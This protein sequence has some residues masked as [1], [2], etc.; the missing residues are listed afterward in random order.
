[1][2]VSEASK[3]LIWLKNFLEELG[4]EQDNCVLYFDNQ[5]VVH[6]GKNPVFHSRTKHIKLRYHFI[7][8]LVN[9]GTLL[10]SKIL[11]SKNPTDM[12]TN[13]VT[14]KKLKLCIVSTGLLMN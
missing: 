8:D 9:D 11:G 13:L 6:L 10:L 2:A 12:F 3:E 14:T 7:R 1:M 4:K 5:S